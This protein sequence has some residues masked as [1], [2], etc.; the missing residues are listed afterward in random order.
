MRACVHAW[1]VTLACCMMA[2]IWASCAE[3]AGPFCPE[4]PPALILNCGVQ[5]AKWDKYEFN[6]ST[7][8]KTGRVVQ[9]QCKSRH[10]GVQRR[11]NVK[12]LVIIIILLDSKW[13]VVCHAGCWAGER[14]ILL[15]SCKHLGDVLCESAGIWWSW[16]STAAQIHSIL[17]I[18]LSK[19]AFFFFR[20]LYFKG[21]FW[22]GCI[23]LTP[24]DCHMFFSRAE[25]HEFTRVTGWRR[26]NQQVRPVRRCSSTRGLLFCVVTERKLLQLL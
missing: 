17:Q 21:F 1:T 22:G 14:T 20:I 15:R 24:T 16:A 11:K 9:G 5:E 2:C 13:G 12:L 19:R 6:R 18:S 7:K 4:S 23:F 8:K 10:T 26:Q 3:T 25:T